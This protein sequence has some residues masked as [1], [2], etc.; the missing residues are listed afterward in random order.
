MARRLAKTKDVKELLLCA[1][2][3]IVHL[4][5]RLTKIEVFI[6]ATIKRRMAEMEVRILYIMETIK[7]ERP[8]IGGLIL[9]DQREKEIK[10]LMERYIVEREPFMQ[11][12][13]QVA[14]EYVRG[15][16]LQ[17]N[18][19]ASTDPNRPGPG[20]PGA[21]PGNPDAEPP[22]AEPGAEAPGTGTGA[23]A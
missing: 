22:A 21:G 19:N 4:D 1:E 10:T 18:Q 7:F 8:L 11:G 15:Q 16:N 3:A 2:A 23:L 20:A 5:E 6:D 14:M 17:A 12:L 9:G 13:A